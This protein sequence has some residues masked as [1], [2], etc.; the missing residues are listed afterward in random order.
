[1]PLQLNHIEFQGEYYTHY[2]LCDYKPRSTGSDQLSQSLIRFKE[3]S[4]L[5]VEAWTECATQELGKIPSI[6]RA[7]I[8][9]ALNSD[10]TDVSLVKQTAL[11]RL[12]KKLALE[13]NG[14]YNPHLLMKSRPTKSVKMLTKMEREKELEDIYSIDQIET[15]NILV[16]DDILTT[17]TT[18]KEII[19]AIRRLNTSCLINLF[20]LADTDHQAVLNQNIALSGDSY[21][22]AEEEW[23]ALAEPDEFYIQLEKLKSQILKDS[24]S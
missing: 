5:D 18:M 2:Y 7:V 12:G 20:T 8:M 6:E 3:G 1:M 10:E 24:F 23:A 17:G 11:D 22:W 21:S 14:A 19:K 9:R 15:E 16:I 13:I 4:R